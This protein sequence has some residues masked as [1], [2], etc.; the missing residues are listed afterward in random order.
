MN[1]SLTAKVIPMRMILRPWF[2]MDI[3]VSMNSSIIQIICQSE[4]LAV[5]DI[6]EKHMTLS[7]SLRIILVILL[8]Q[9]DN[10]NNGWPYSQALRA[11]LSHRRGKIL[12]LEQP[13]PV[14]P[15][16]GPT[17]IATEG[18]RIVPAAA[19]A[20]RGSPSVPT[21]EKTA[22]MASRPE[23]RHSWCRIATA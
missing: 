9:Y 13:E 21:R 6:F 18:G 17:E 11:V 12:S 22:I 5:I 19:L 3:K 15:W 1:V 4:S 16:L 20:P 14:I 10:E 23:P 7:C 8:K 2:V